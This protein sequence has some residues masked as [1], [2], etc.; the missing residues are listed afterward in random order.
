MGEKWVSRLQALGVPFCFRF[1]KS[2]LKRLTVLLKPPTGRKVNVFLK[3][4]SGGEYLLLMGSFEP[5]KLEKV[6]PKRWS[7]EVL[8]QNFKSRGFNL[9]AMRLR[10]SSKMSKLLVY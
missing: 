6:Y 10:D 4:L 5:P 3:R 2:L 7:I 8:F 9:E 1:P